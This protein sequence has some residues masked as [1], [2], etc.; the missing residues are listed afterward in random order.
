M[1][2]DSTIPTKFGP[3]EIILLNQLHFLRA[4][5]ISVSILQIQAVLMSGV[6]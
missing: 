2:T 5:G 3:E 1:L 4:A 6:S